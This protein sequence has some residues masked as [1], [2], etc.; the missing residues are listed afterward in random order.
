MH[1]VGAAFVSTGRFVWDNELVTTPSV[2]DETMMAV[3]IA[4]AHH[5]EIVELAVDEGF[6]MAEVIADAGDILDVAIVLAHFEGA[7]IYD[8]W[9]ASRLPVGYVNALVN[10]CL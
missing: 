4:A 5:R 7:R 2:L 6:E 8:L 10:G 3:R 1:L 9:K